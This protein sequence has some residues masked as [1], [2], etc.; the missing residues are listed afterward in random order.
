MLA[1]APRPD[2][3]IPA[4]IRAW[5]A[6]CGVP[7]E[8]PNLIAA[9]RSAESAYIEFRRVQRSQKRMQVLRAEQYAKSRHY[10]IYASNVVP[11]PLHTAS[12]MRAMM[13][14]FDQFHE[15]GNIDIA[16]GVEERLARQRQYLGKGVR[17][18][19]LVI[20][21]SVLYDR[22]FSSDVMRG[23][24]AH[25]LAGPH[26]PGLSLGIIPRGAA[27]GYYAA[28]TFSIYGDTVAIETVSA[29]ITVTQPREIALYLRCFTDLSRAAVSG[30]AGRDLITQA[31]AV[32][33]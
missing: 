21:E 9:S 22:T 3:A 17:R 24:L 32:L 5:C 6:I 18:C 2:A 31:L 30:S 27:R 16:E 8:I 4:D 23:Q 10:R 7:E 28:E 14:H 29:I 19:E 15:A 12:Y 20:E 26:W 25:L 33:G 13:E 1:P 11:W